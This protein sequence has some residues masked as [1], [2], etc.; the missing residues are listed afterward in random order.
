MDCNIISSTS[1]DIYHNLVAVNLPVPSGQIQILPKHAEMFTVLVTGDI[2]LQFN[3]EKKII[4]ISG[5]ECHVQDNMVTII[6]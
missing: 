4:S 1:N 5:G 6:L 2:L 3:R